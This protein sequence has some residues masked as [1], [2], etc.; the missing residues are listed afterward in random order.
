MATVS[1][2]KGNKATWQADR[3]R[4]E[5]SGSRMSAPSIA[6][7]ISLHHRPAAECAPR[8]HTR[9]MPVDRRETCR[10]CAYVNEPADS[11]HVQG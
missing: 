6:L 10:T 11:Y 5:V 9:H 8:V 7:R 4:V 2:P 1:V 3:A